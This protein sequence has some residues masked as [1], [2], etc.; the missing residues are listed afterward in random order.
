M[1]I[2]IFINNIDSKNYLGNGA[3]EYEIYFTYLHLKHPDKFVLRKL[4]WDNI[5]NFS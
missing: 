5:S 1:V 3:S 4:E 2:L